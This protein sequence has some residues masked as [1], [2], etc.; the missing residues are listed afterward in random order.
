MSDIAA[1]FSQ[2]ELVPSVLPLA[3]TQKLN[4]TFEGI[5]VEPG[6]EFQ[7][8]NLKNAPRVTLKVDPE[9]TF[10]LVMIGSWSSYFLYVLI[11]ICRSRQFVEKES[12]GRRMASLAR[13]EH[14]REQHQRRH[15]R[16][17]TPTTVRLAGASAA[18]RRASLPDRALRAS[19]STTCRSKVHLESEIQLKEFHGKASTW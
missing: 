3:P 9:S 14:S 18:Y 11:L 12:V 2:A 4:V 17:S 7:I 13:C 16:R 19:G 1:A 6:K 5:P 15:Q 10:S 8:R